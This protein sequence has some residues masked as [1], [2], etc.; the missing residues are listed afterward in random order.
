[1]SNINEFRQYVAA[2]RPRKVD[3][4][5]ASVLQK[6]FFFLE[7]L[8]CGLIPELI[9][10]M[11]NIDL[12]LA[13]ST[14]DEIHLALQTLLELVDNYQ[15]KYAKIIIDGALYEGDYMLVEA[16]NIRSIGPNFILAPKA[17]PTDKK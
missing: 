15:P 10:K 14:V 2:W 3:I 11:E 4:G 7:G 12:A 9:K 1:S 8:G 16:L 13:K 17:D 5:S 6:S